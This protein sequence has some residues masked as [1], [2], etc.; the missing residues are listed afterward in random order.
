MILLPNLIN[1]F[2]T[3]TDVYQYLIYFYKDFLKYTTI[4]SMK[5]F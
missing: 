2:Y 4:K 1:V 3:V 5:I